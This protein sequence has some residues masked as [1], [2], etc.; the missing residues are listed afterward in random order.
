[1]ARPVSARI[2]QVPVD[3][4]GQRGRGRVALMADQRPRERDRR[5]E[6]CDQVDQPEHDVVPGPDDRPPQDPSRADSAWRC[7]RSAVKRVGIDLGRGRLLARRRPSA[8]G[9]PRSTDGRRLMAVDF[10]NIK[11]SWPGLSRLVPATHERWMAGGH[12]GHGHSSVRAQWVPGTRPGIIVVEIKDRDSSRT[13]EGDV[14]WTA[15]SLPW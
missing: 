13:S 15:R 8:L 10:P 6:Q 5:D 3:A 12:A 4:A 14:G 7:K 2:G 9:D 11:P 1:M